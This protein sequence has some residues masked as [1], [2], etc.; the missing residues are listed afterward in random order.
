MKHAHT[1]LCHI[2]ARTDCERVGGLFVAKNRPASSG[3]EYR[4]DRF[5]FY[6]RRRFFNLR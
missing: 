4:S 1:R 6:L 3:R 2:S 5:K